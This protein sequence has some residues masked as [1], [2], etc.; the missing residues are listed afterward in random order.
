MLSASQ[1][2][3]QSKVIGDINNGWIKLSNGL[4]IQWGNSNTGGYARTV[5]F[6]IPF[7]HRCFNV[8][9]SRYNTTWEHTGSIVSIDKEKFS[10]QTRGYYQNTYV[11]DNYWMAI[12]Y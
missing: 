9:L 5:Y 1:G 4:I 8:F 7:P 11:V 2:S 3:N 12:G 10:Y 6:N